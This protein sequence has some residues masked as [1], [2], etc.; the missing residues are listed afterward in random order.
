M[1]HKQF[2]WTLVM[3][4]V[5]A[6][7][8]G[9]LSTQLFSGT[10]AMADGSAHEG[11]VI[12]AGK[13]LL[14]DKGGHEH[15][16]LAIGPDGNPSLILY[17]VDHNVRFVAELMAKGNPRLFFSDQNGKIRSVIGTSAD[18]SPLLQLKDENRAIVW[19]AP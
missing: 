11:T 10:A 3:T 15:G 8:G 6:F 18:G 1:N 13:F 7:L 2:T 4:I 9:T 14:V 19:S 12:K 16:S 17:D 5:A